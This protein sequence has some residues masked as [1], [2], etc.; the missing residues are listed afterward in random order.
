MVSRLNLFEDLDR[1]DADAWV[2]HLA[3]DVVMQF[4]NEDPVYGRATC[5]ERALSLFH[6]VESISHHIVAHWEHGDATIVETA[7]TFGRGQ[8]G[9]LTIPMVTIF[10]T[11][12]HGLI[13]DYRVY[14]DPSGLWS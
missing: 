5:R 8:T 1:M 9:D 12:G 4:A 6:S 3:P 14:L 13:A 10:R 7:V 2:S 11:E